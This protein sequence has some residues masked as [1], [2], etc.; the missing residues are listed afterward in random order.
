MKKMHNALAWCGVVAGLALFGGAQSAEASVKLSF[1]PTGGT[2]TT[3]QVAPGNS[4][5]L[6]LY[7]I[8]T[9]EV[10]TGVN[11]GAG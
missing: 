8:S 10:T 1:S 5:T 11:D 3:A 6:S 4:V 2:P 9:A 7:L